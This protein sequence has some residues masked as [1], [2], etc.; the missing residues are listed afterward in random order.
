MI[1]STCQT[2]KKDF[3]HYPSQRRKYCGSSCVPTNIGNAIRWKDKTPVK[4]AC[5]EC[6]TEFFV[7]P[8]RAIR[9]NTKYCCYACHQIGEG[10]KGGKI[11]GLRRSEYAERQPG[12]RK[13]YPKKDGRHIHRTKAEQKIGRPLL[14]GEIVHHDD[15]N[16]QNFASENLIV[17]PNQAAHARLHIKKML[18]LRKEKHGY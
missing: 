9:Q 14:P 10:K 11:V 15:E 5:A 16:K 18:R 17:L 4:F 13:S 3:S 7:R 8:S 6:S 1:V 12:G 2:C